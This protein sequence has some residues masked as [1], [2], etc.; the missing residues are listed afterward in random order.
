M[1]LEEI[2]ETFRQNSMTKS[3]YDFSSR[4]LGKSRSYL[5]WL[6]AGQHNPSTDA[7]CHLLFQLEHCAD[8]ESVEG[9]ERAVVSQDAQKLV[10]GAITDSFGRRS[11]RVTS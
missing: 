9:K 10:R 3:Q 11:K 2:Y 7:L 6:K 1:F 8:D 5:S 4:W